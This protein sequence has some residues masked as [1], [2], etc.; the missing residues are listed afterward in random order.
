[1]ADETEYAEKLGVPP[2]EAV[3]HLKKAIKVEFVKRKNWIEI[4]LWGKKRQNEDLEKIAELLHET[5]VENIVK[6]EPSFQ[7]YLDAIKKQQA[8]AKSRQP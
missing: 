8:A 2:E 1:I 6:I 4:G 5:A 7:Q 3:S